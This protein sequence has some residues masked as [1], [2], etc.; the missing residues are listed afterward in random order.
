MGIT[1]LVQSPADNGA[2][3]SVAAIDERDWIKGNKESPIVLIE[4]S[5]FQCVAC[6][7]YYPLLK[8]LASE[9]GDDV[10][11]VYRH[12]PLRQIFPNAQIAG[13]AA[14]A[15][16]KQGK[17]WEMHDMIFEGQRNWSRQRQGQAE[18]T[19]ASYAA[20]LNLDIEQFKRDIHSKSVEDKVNSDYQSGVRAGVNSTPIF[21]LNGKRIQNPRSYEEFRKLIQAAI[22][23]G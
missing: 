12:F 2:P 19:F 9:F 4:Y 8:E 1:K 5:D 18:E 14:E 17:F 22:D 7:N 23:A 3:V 16:G 15:A 20:A 21:F 10:A 11:F 13:Q 6:A